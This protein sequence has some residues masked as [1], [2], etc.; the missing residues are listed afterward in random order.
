[1]AT[2]AIG[3]VQGCYS[4]L[5]DLLARIAFDETCDRL[6]FTGDLV[7]RG[8]KSGQVLR[9][10]KSLGERAVS[11]LGNHDL[12]LIALA[13]SGM[14]APR[15]G[16][17]L[18]QVLAGADAEELVAWLRFRPLLHHDPNLGFTLVHAGLPPQWDLGTAGRCEKKKNKLKP[19]K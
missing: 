10:V 7:N 11:V 14:V 6:W 13:Y 19:I 2:Y 9:F 8:P 18:K 16:D 15:K 1:M 12:H 3:D 4:Q 5:L 17:T